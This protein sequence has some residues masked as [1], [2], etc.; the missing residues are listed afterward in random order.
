VD[1]EWVPSLSSRKK[2]YHSSK[3]LQV[4]DTVLLISNEN[5]ITHWLLGTVI[6]EGVDM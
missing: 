4:G 3:N 6:E 1:E 2:L 5:A